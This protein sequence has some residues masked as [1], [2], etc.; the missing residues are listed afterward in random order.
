[1]TYEINNQVFPTPPFPTTTHLIAC[2]NEMN[3]D[4]GQY[5]V[6]RGS[7]VNPMREWFC[8]RERRSKQC[9]LAEKELGNG[10]IQ[11]GW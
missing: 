11:C 1:M 4:D 6:P 9:Y 7:D 3:R 2:M 8:Q 10:L 5:E